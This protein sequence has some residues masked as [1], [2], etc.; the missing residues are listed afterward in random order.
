M[1][2]K[3]IYKET[4][5]PTLKKQ[6]HVH[7]IYHNPTTIGNQLDS[8]ITYPGNKYPISGSIL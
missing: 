3:T 5:R 7:S 4:D 1:K 6:F 2:D 8:P